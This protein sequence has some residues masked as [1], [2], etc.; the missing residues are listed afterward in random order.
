VKFYTAHLRT[1]QTPRLVREGFSWGALIFGPVWLLAHGAWL[2]AILVGALDAGLGLMTHGPLQAVLVLWA[3]WLTGLFGQDLR[4][5]T[6]LHRGFDELHVIAARDEAAAFG[7]LLAV[8][9]DL[10]EAEL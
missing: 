9:P 1:G 7:R 8:R 3:A 6:L 2:A 10:A 5:W 4:R